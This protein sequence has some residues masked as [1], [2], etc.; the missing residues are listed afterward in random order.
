MTRIL[1]ILIPILFFVTILLTFVR[2]LLTPLFLQIEYRRPGFPADP[3]GFTLAER[4]RYAEISQ[5]YLLTNAGTDYFAP[6]HLADGA[7][8]YNERESSHMAD[9]QRLVSQTLLVWEI[10]GV[11][12]LV[13]L[14]FLLWK[15]LHLFWQILFEAGRFTLIFI[16]AAGIAVMVV[17]DQAFVFFHHLFFSANTWLFLYSDTLIRLFPVAFWQDIFLSAAIGTAL[18]GLIVMLLARKRIQ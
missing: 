3:Y 17:W 12:L 14:S 8:L 11:I 2:V 7:P 1:R 6:Y 15:D 10:C 13:I 9:V 16:V 5:A 18:V 4:L